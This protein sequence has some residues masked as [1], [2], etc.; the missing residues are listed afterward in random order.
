MKIKTTMFHNGDFKLY[1][2]PETEAEKTMLD[3]MMDNNK[4]SW[5][6]DKENW[7]P[8]RIKSAVIKFWNEEEKLVE[9]G[10]EN[11]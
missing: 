4:A 3:L 1:L 11:D 9:P 5:I 8:Y 6:A 7:S 2:T 10:L